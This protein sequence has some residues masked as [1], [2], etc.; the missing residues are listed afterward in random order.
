[1]LCIFCLDRIHFRDQLLQR[2]IF[3]APP[4]KYMQTLVLQYG[5][6]ELHFDAQLSEQPFPVQRLVVKGQ[7]P[8]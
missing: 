5:F 4:L 1:M 6:N 2:V 7:K 8:A 3:T